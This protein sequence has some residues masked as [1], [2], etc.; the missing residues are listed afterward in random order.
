MKPALRF[1]EKFLWGAA[2]ASYQVEG[3]IEN[4][5]WAMA[6]R[7]GRVPPC[8][9]AC[10]HYNRYESDFD[11]AQKLGHNSHRIS[12]EWARI[13]PEEGQFDRNEVVHYKNVIKAL[14]ARG[15]EPI[16]TLW[17]FTLPAWFA[18]DRGFENPKSV[19]RFGK[20]AEFVAKEILNEVKFVQT[21]NEPLVWAGNGYIRGYWPPFRKNYISYL[22]VVRNL[23]TAH[24]KAYETIK[25]VRGDLLVGIA[26]NNMFFSAKGVN[27]L[28][29]LMAVVSSYW[30]NRY[31]LS[32]IRRESD[33]IGLNFYKTLVFG[34]KSSLPKSD[35]G[36]DIFPEGIYHVLKELG[37]YKKPIYVTENGVADADDSIRKNFIR[38]HLIQVHGAIQEGVDVRGYFYWSLLDNYEWAH[39]FEKRFGLIEVDFVTQ[40]RR[41]R[42]SAIAYK[43][44]C[45][46]N[47]LETES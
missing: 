38:D 8:G 3:G 17:H 4:C 6:G 19:E 27:P 21:I 23:A 18:N 1:P 30:W 13:E 24:Q 22:K 43:N 7:A 20:Y 31:F 15:L 14:R 10:D 47:A 11:N 40:E 35:M 26:K 29:Y 34:P 28:N 46:T 37:R 39:G 12:I 32:K 36:W 25:T 16:V 45:E 9:S 5:D 42:A 33:F 44:I 2:C 41:I